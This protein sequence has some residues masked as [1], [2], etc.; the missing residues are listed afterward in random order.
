MIMQW[1]ENDRQMVFVF[2][3]LTVQLRMADPV[4]VSPISFQHLPS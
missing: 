2:M 4:G 1:E 3:K